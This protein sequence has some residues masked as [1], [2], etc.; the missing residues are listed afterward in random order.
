[1]IEIDG[2]F[3]E[4][5]GQIIRT[6][7]ALAAITGQG[8]EIRNIRANRP[9]P[10]LAAQH[11]HAIKAVELLSCGETRGLE[12]RSQNLMF[13]PGDLRGVHAELNIGTA[14][15]ITLLLQCLIPVALFA[16]GETVVTVTGGTDVLWAPPIDYYNSVF[17]KALREMGCDV[18]LVLKRRGYYPKG[19]G[20]VQARIYPV[21]GNLHG[22]KPHEDKTTVVRGISHSRGLPLHV[23]ERQAKAATRVLHD[24]GYS[25][26]IDIDVG[27]AG[28]AQPV[29]IATGSGITLWQGYKGGSALGKPGKRA[30]LVGEEAAHE[31]LK[32]LNTG[33]NVD[34]HLADQLI[35]YIALAEGGSELRVREMTEHLRTNMYVTKQFLSDVEFEITKDADVITI[36]R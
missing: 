13:Q 28:R 23:S 32:E 27:D 21:K 19:G 33:A 17:L 29:N 31:I 4:G 1:M 3:G 2:S 6:A 5:G 20:I 26:E 7:I 35:P 15:S 11:L 9:N 24:S 12:L 22:F 25:A 16:E 36:R 30:E 8:V 10:G 34:I 14:G 18:H